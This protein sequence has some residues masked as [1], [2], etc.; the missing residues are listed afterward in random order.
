MREKRENAGDIFGFHRELMEEYQRFVH[1]FVQIS[2][3]RLREFVNEKLLHDKELWPEPLLQ[4]SPAYKRAGKIDELVSKGLLHEETGQIF[5]RE[6]NTS[7]ELYQHQVSSIEKAREWKSFVVTTGTGSGKSFCYFIP[8]VDSI[9]RNPSL[10]CPVAIIVYPT[11]ALVN[12][13]LSAL[14]KLKEDYPKRTGKEFPITFARYTGETSED[15]R[16]KIRS[17]PPHLILTNYMMLELMMIRSSDKGVLREG[18]SPLFLVFDELHTYR[19]RQ[20]ADVAMLIRRLKARMN[21][22]PVMHIGTSATMVTHKGGSAEERRQAISKFTSLF[23]GAEIGVDCVIEETFEPISA[24]GP[25]SKEELIETADKPLPTKVEDFRRHP[26]VRCLEYELGIVMEEDGQLRR[27]TPR[28]LSQVGAKLAQLIGKSEET[29]TKKLMEVL[30][31]SLEIGENNER[32]LFAFKLHQFVSQGKAIYA[33]LESP[34]KREF[35]IGEPPATKEHPLWAALRF[36]RVCGQEYYRVL[37]QE[38]KI[39]PLPPKWYELAENDKAGYLMPSF[40]DMLPLEELIPTEWKNTNGKIATTWR[41]RIPEKCWVLPNGEVFTTPVEG[42]TLMWWQ[43]KTLWLCLRCGEHYTAKEREYTKLAILSSEGR[44]ST[45]TILASTLLRFARRTKVIRPKLLSFTD[46]RQDASLQAGHFNH[47]VQVSALRSALYKALEEHKELRYDSIAKKVVKQLGVTIDKIAKNPNLDPDSPM[48]QKV[49]GIYEEL[50]EYRLYEELKR[51]WRFVHP[52]LEDVG[53]LKIEYDGL[54]D[55]CARDELFE[56]LPAMKELSQNERYEI[57]RT[58]LDYCRKK[59]A[60]E[61]P[62]LKKEKIDSLRTRC[63]H[64]L[65]EASGWWDPETSYLQESAKLIRPL[66]S[67]YP[68]S[69]GVM[70]TPLSFLG[71]YLKEKLNLDSKAVD[72]FL[73]NIANMLTSQGFFHSFTERGNQCYRLNAHCLIWKLG[74]GTPPPPDLWVKRTTDLSTPINPFFKKFY[75]ESVKELGSLEAR[76]HTA[77]VNGRGE[78]ETREKRFRGELQPELPYLV[79]SPT[80]ELGVDIAEL[81][82]IHMRNIPPTPAN[83]AQRS[84]RAGRQGQPGVII[85]FCGAYTPH[86]QYFFRHREEMVAGNV[87]APRLDLTNKALLKV[88]IFAE[89][90]AQLGLSMEN[91]ITTVIDHEKEGLPIRDN[92][93][94][95]LHLPDRELG[96]L[97]ARLRKVFAYDQKEFSSISWFDEKW[98]KERLE[99]A[100]KIFDEAFDRWRELY[101]SASKQLKEAQELIR[102]HDRNSQEKGERLEK[103]ARRQLNLLIQQEPVGREESDF[104]PYR[105]LATENFLPGYNFP[106]LPVRAWVQRGEG[107]FITRGRFLAISEFAPQNIVYHEGCKWQV[108]RFQLPPGGLKE[109]LTKKKICKTCATVW[110]SDADICT[111]CGVRFDASNSYLLDLMEMPN[112]VLRRRERITCNEEERVRQG[113]LVEMAY[114]FPESDGT[115]EIVKARAGELLELQYLPS[116]TIFNINRGLRANPKGF[117]V[118]LDT[119][120]LASEESITK[121]KTCEFSRVNLYVEDTQNLLRIQIRD[122]NLKADEVFETTLMYTL[123]RG[124]EYAFQLEDSELEVQALGSGRGKTIVFY[125]V[126]EGGAGVL[127][128]LVEESDA[129]S[130]VS[131]EALKLL[132]FDPQT[133]KDLTKDGHRACYECLVSFSN[134]LQGELLDRHRIK[135]FLLQLK[136]TKV[137]IQYPNRS[138]EEHYKWL[139][140]FVDARSSL[141]K[142]FLEILYVK[143][144]RLPAIAQ[145][146]IPDVGCV[147]DFFYE[148]NICIFCDGSVHDEPHQHAKDEEVRKKLVSIGYRVIAIR[149]DQE[150]I[151]QLRRYPEVFGT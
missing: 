123:E 88:H 45:T 55:L 86:D 43:A 112:V 12:S 109:R 66:P 50:I 69:R 128:R 33:T 46:N 130:F 116:A 32:G 140:V 61:A 126:M 70:L 78:R 113:Y 68:L 56:S 38:N 136:N 106:P 91:S 31:K 125:E 34:D 77:Q 83:Y 93:R 59:F 35:S 9:V 40:P 138:R 65:S 7:F 4:I 150:L 98:I 47:F 48:A 110:K 103:E 29:C 24:G 67:G 97:E 19:G 144:Y 11:N 149:Y 145:K 92:I 81:D 142:N 132:H 148:P 10:Q 122:P 36:C 133:G 119:G 49:M 95:Y 137:E 121:S 57:L 27:Q 73:E 107:E 120:E 8:I 151:Q 100:P 127:K 105:Y 147:A 60:I 87:R 146:Q 114:C 71:R 115:Q 14:Q 118:N 21:R 44:S 5:R 135:D 53:L 74:D 23:F 13:Q 39:K 96:E 52:N 72:P 1:S 143:G 94:P 76:E 41:D 84:G 64:E 89:W 6:D 111:V 99:E 80:M 30:K 101:Q 51:G 25:P 17:N 104:Y 79:C 22:N 63:E 26:W 75:K 141:E 134:Q 16:E 129:L 117:L 20:G 58:V 37:R 54:T 139:K 62:I 42:A 18:A 15:E 28:T 3:E 2:D 131:E 90:L 85:A 124:I 82:A 102:R 108:E